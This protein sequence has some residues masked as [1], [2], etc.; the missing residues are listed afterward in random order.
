MDQ[1][2]KEANKVVQHH[3][4]KN[5]V[6]GRL[7]EQAVFPSSL[8]LTSIS[9]K[10]SV[11]RFLHD[12]IRNLGCSVVEPLRS[13]HVQGWHGTRV[14]NHRWFLVVETHLPSLAGV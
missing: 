4:T 6:Y 3:G 13:T 12:W 5:S 10:E 9:R 1:V 7:L 14:W 11:A 2:V 8:R